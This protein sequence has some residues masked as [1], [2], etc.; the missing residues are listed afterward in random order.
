M[1]SFRRERVAAS[2]RADLAQRYPS[3]AVQC[4]ARGTRVVGELPVA[5]EL[6]E[7]ARFQIEIT[8]D[9]LFPSS[10]PTIRE[11]GGRIPIEIERHVFADGSFCLFHPAYYWLH[12][13]QRKPLSALLDGP[14]RSFLLYQLCIE[15][16]QPWPHGELMHGLD[17]ELQ[18]FDE[19]FETERR[20]TER[21]LRAMSRGLTSHSLCP[22]GTRRSV[23]NCHR[24]CLQL[25]AEPRVR[26]LVSSLAAR[27]GQRDAH[28]SG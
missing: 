17:G 25:V 27:L 21:C 20:L 1:Y 26:T 10:R 13:F 3:L 19:L 8:C 22:C 23:L 14:V 5:D 7:L 15:H 9:R 6:G 24:V 4:T 2:V 16:G 28:P 12:G 18:F 11:T